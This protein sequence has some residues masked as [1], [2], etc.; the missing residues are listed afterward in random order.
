MN[1]EFQL[2]KDRENVVIRYATVEKQVLDARNLRD[3]IEKKNKELHREIELLTGKIKGAAGEK[4]RIC[5]ILDE[6]VNLA[7]NL[8]D[9]LYHCCPTFFFQCHELKL[10]QKEVEKLK[11]ENTGLDSKLKW[12]FSKLKIETETRETAEKKIE[13]LIAEIYQFKFKEINRAKEEVEVERNMLAGE[14]SN[15]FLIIRS[16]LTSK[17][18]CNLSTEKQ[19][20]EQNATLITLKHNIEEKSKKIEILERKC[21]QLEFDLENLNSKHEAMCKDREKISQEN[22][23]MS[24]QVNDSQCLLDK[25]MLKIAELQSNQNDLEIIRTQFSLE[26]ESNRQLKSEIDVL[27]AQIEEQNLETEKCYAKETELLQLNKELTDTVVKLKNECSLSSSK[28]TAV[29]LENEMIK[30]DKSYYENIIGDLRHQLDE[31]VKKR[32]SDC[33]LM[34][35]HISEKTKLV[36]SLQ[37]KVEEFTGELEA[38]QKKHSVSVKELT[39]E[40][41]IMKKKADAR[42]E[43]SEKKSPSSSTTSESSVESQSNEYPTISLEPSQKS[44]ID[45]IVRLQNEIVR[46]SEKIDFLE[47]HQAQ[48]VDELKRLRKTNKK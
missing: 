25:Q 27:T 16:S 33:Q 37:R 8:I 47:N 39:R 36:E 43:Q 18:K 14:F 31:E 24:Q 28:T 2:R 41:N 44:L 48:L 23:S 17:N 35:K 46:Q 22:L 9:I 4:T 3:A 10:S 29:T 21:Q 38:Q 40:I 42:L 1:I 32:N 11:Y 45:R 6:K 26:K 34:A 30:K 19:M 20:M 12:H 5:G 13:E 7:S 15:R